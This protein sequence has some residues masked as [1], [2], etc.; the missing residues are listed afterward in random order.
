MTH[1]KTVQVEDND[2]T[3]HEYETYFDID[4]GI[5]YVQE[6]FEDGI[7]I[8]SAEVEAQVTAELQTTLDDEEFE[9]F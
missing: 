7:M 9:G 1:K 3:I 6:I 5:I 2:G 8:S 4:D